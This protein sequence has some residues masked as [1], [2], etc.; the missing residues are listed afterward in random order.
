MIRLLHRWPGII[1]ALL[2]ITLALS[3][4]VLAIFPT[5]EKLGNPSQAEAGLSV[6][7]LAGR[8]QSVYPGVEQIR[9][10]PSGRITAYWFD[11]GTPGA[12][13]IDPATGQGVGSVDAST[14]ELWMTDFHRSL[15]LGDNGRWTMAI[16]AAAMLV[17]AIS[18]LLLV[19]RRTGGWR[20]YFRKLKGP[21]SGRLHVE[22][23]RVAVIGLALS[24]VTALWMTAS[25]FGFIPEGMGG[26]LFPDTVSGMM[27]VPPTDLPALQDLPVAELRGLTFPFDGD[28]GDVFTLKT[29]AGTGYVDQGTGEMLAWESLNTWE[30][31]TETVYMLHT[32][33]GA[34]W[35]GIILGLMA[36]TVPLMA[37][38][39]IIL[40]LANRRARPRIRN[41]AAAGHAETVLLVGSEGGSTWG[42]AATLHSALTEAGQKVHV[43]PM[44]GFAPRR[45]GHAKR[46][47]ALAATYGDGDA[48]S[49]AKGFL[50]KLA[51]LET[52]PEAPLS[53]LGFGDRSF[54]E[55]CGFA[56]QVTRLAAEKGWAEL[57]PIHTVDRQSPQDFLRW[58]RELGAVLGIALELNHQPVLPR[59]GK[60]T[61]ISRRDYGA[62]MQVPTAILRFALP[63]AS[64]MQKLTGRGFPRFS[65]GDLVGIVP[66]GSDVPRFYSLASST[67]DGFLEICVRRHE[68]GLCSGQL[69]TL[70]QGDTARAFIRRNDFRPNRGKAP[71]ILIGAG[72]GIGPLA[73]FIRGNKSRQPMHLFFG[74]RHP[75]SDLLYDHELPGWQSEDRLHSLATAFSRTADR[76]HVQDVLRRD[77]AKVTALVAAGAQIMVCGGRSMAHGVS[78]ALDEILEP[79]G[80]TPAM[81]KAE[82]RYAEDVY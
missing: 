70:E 75:D 76:A 69:T 23:A 82:G 6:A 16:G 7:E 61:L 77:A 53:V 64:L 3:G 24:S 65:A 38:T 47:I 13:V 20:R 11:N 67:R 25:T 22:F 31:I 32:G 58:G 55:Y 9:R 1:A 43:A 28:P 46:F 45:Y 63:R 54:P 48:P 21:L 30:Q 49:S 5:L 15:F 41:N 4:S 26:P 29:N 62:E 36:L 35:L 51:A 12:A 66:E 68:G 78:E 81:L 56:R 17:L 73:G 10:A 80:L 60:L 2:L 42:F 33:R 40:W 52:A 79:M 72:T 19:L 14:L 44:A 50:D 74:T 18:G 59:T 8:I 27:D 71:V 57:L 39:G 37:L 34:A